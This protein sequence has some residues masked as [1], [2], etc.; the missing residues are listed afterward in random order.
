MKIYCSGIGGIG[1]SAYAA[2]QQSRGQ[3]VSGSDHT[4]SALI[5]DLRSQGITVTLAQDGSAVPKDADLFVYSEA[6]PADAPER[7]RA[8][9]LK[10]PNQSYFAALGDLSREY[11]VVAVC[12]THGKSSTTAM[13]ARVLL[14]AG[15]DPT[16]IVGTKLRELGGRNWRKGTSDLFLLEACEYRRSFLHLSPDI[17]L[18]TTADGDHFDAFRS[19]EDYR[20]AFIDFIDL[21]PADGVV[22]THMGDS[23]CAVIVQQAHR[24]NVDVDGLPLPMLSVPGAHMRRNAQLVLGLSD[25]LAL[26][27]DTT[28]RALKGYAGCWRR[29]EVK[30]TIGDDIIIVDDY[31]HHPTEVR[32]TIEALREAY[33][34]RRIVVVFQPHMH[35]R[36]LKLYGAFTK[37]FSSA[38]LVIITDVYEARKD[39]ET[40]RVDLKKFVQ[41]IEKGSGVSALLGGSLGAVEQRLRSDLLQ[42][43][44]VLLFLGAGDITNLASGLVGT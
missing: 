21:L 42:P 19:M 28:Q 43:H 12:G 17:I 1:L 26:D 23:D 40:A 15:L 31:G 9:E 8:T 38:D 4:E 44:D 13:S 11:R 27:R 32:A 35:D 10:I 22:L 18:L 20:Q 33:G 37:A 14:E 29:M 39:V 6:I 24:R 7:L 25:A 5:A 34:K 41:D 3:S 30:G 2:L 16:I 36:T